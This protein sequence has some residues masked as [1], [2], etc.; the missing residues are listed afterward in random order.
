MVEY[1]FGLRAFETWLTQETTI[2]DC[3]T[4]LS[5]LEAWLRSDGVSIRLQLTF[6]REHVEDIFSMLEP[7]QVPVAST[8]AVT[9]KERRH[10]P[11][12]HRV[13]HDMH[14]SC[15]KRWGGADSNSFGP[16]TDVRLEHKSAAGQYA[17]QQRQ[18]IGNDFLDGVCT[19][20][21]TLWKCVD[22]HMDFAKQAR[23]SDPRQI[24]R[25]SPEILDLSV[26][27]PSS[28]PDQTSVVGSGRFMRRQFKPSQPNLTF[29]SGGKPWLLDCPLFALMHAAHWPFHTRPAMWSVPSRSGRGCGRTGSPRCRRVPLRRRYP[30][31]SLGVVP[32]PYRQPLCRL[33]TIMVPVGPLP[34]PAFCAP[35]LTPGAHSPAI[36]PQSPAFRPFF[37][38]CRSVGGPWGW[39]G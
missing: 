22:T 20:K 8:R 3:F 2:P 4:T 30:S 21:D 19:A 32:A 12:M 16:S 29:C 6:V 36:S 39:W 15:V 9:P 28:I 38:G 37:H 5:G 17:H 1:W 25:L 31:A 14:G 27:S 11:H 10:T 18:R 23:I 34:G 7:I 26:I 24:A 35:T 13:G 33:V